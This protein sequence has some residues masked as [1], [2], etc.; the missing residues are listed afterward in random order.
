MRRCSSF[1]TEVSDEEGTSRDVRVAEIFESGQPG[2]EEGHERLPILARHHKVE[3]LVLL[4]LLSSLSV[5]HSERRSKTDQLSHAL[6]RLGSTEDLDPKVGEMFREARV[7]LGVVAG[8]AV[9]IYPLRQR[10]RS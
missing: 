8:V 9:H 4:N 5:M 6:L 1:W 10:D 2:S 7:K 3:L